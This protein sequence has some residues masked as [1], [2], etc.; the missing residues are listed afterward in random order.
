MR[1]WTIHP[2]YLDRQG[3]LAVWREGLLAQ[4]VLQNKTRGYRNHPQ[5]KRFKSSQDAVGAISAYLSTVYEEAVRRGYHF[6]KDKINGKEFD[7]QVPCTRGQL[8][9]EWEHLREKLR[10]RDPARYRGLE[11]LQEPEPHPLFRI[12]EGDMEEWEVGGNRRQR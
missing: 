3:L 5:L 4:S 10:Q 12:I 9:F 6:D 2:Q 11:N 1:L 7:G 8:L